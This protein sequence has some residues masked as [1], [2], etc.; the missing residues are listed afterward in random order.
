MYHIGALLCLVAVYD[1]SQKSKIVVGDTSV[2]IGYTLRVRLWRKLLWLLCLKP[3]SFQMEKLAAQS[4]DLFCL[5]LRYFVCCHG[6]CICYDYATLF[7]LGMFMWFTIVIQA[8]QHRLDTLLH[9]IRW[10]SGLN[11]CTK[12]LLRDVAT[13]INR[14]HS[15]SHLLSLHY[16]HSSNKVVPQGFSILQPFFA[17]TQSW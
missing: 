17:L 10:S 13:V 7:D 2:L 1:A 11:S 16:T 8:E 3:S 6:F 4:D 12:W 5:L 14:L 9:C 15:V